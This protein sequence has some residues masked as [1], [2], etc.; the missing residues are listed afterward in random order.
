MRW[1]PSA[2]AARLGAAAGLAAIV[3]SAP[4][5]SLGWAASAATSFAAP[6]TAEIP[7][8]AAADDSA[9]WIG[10]LSSGEKTTPVAETQTAGGVKWYL[11][12]TKTGVVGWIKHA[13]NEPSKNADSFFRALPAESRDSAVEIPTSSAAAQR[14]AMIIPVN[15][16]GRSVIVPVTFNRSVNAE[17]LLDTGASMTMISRRLATN[18][19]LPSS[20]AGLFSG[21]GGTVSAEIARVDSIK[22]GD[23]EV[24][25]MAVSI[26][27]I[28]RLPH[29]EGLLGM[30]FLGRFQVSVDPAKKLL[31]LTPR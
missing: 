5:I 16:K 29:F 26:H 13:A 23:A 3:L 10:T 12:K 18:L 9:L 7:V 11:V 15:L 30:D 19:A 31:V 21:I 14:G 25:G 28:P 6:E 20:G 2:P 27:D 8:Y 24:S 4:P 17:L 22:V 1:Q